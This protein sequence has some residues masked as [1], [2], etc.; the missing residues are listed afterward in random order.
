MRPNI[1]GMRRKPYPS[2]VSDEEGIFEKSNEISA[3]KQPA[4]IGLRPIRL[5]GYA[6]IAHNKALRP[7]L[8][9]YAL[10]ALGSRL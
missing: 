4:R 3:V 1:T 8:Y 2:D 10:K 6:L 9:L 7:T 5:L